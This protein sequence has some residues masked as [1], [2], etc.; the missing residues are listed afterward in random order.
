MPEKYCNA[1][2]TVIMG[3]PEFFFLKYEDL[4]NRHKLYIEKNFNI[5]K[6]SK[7]LLTLCEAINKQI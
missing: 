7:S 3:E 6:H 2:G 5:T 1:G 4:I